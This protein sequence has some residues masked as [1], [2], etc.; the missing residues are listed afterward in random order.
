MNSG[1]SHPTI[2]NNQSGSA[3]KRLKVI[4]GDTNQ[5]TTLI[6]AIHGIGDQK[7]FETIQ[8]VAHRL[9][10]YLGFEGEAPL[11][12]FHPEFNAV[13]NASGKS[14]AYSFYAEPKVGLAEVYWADISNEAE[15]SGDTVEESKAWARTVIERLH[16]KDL[17]KNLGE[18]PSVDYQKTQ[19]VL[20][21][22]IET[23]ATLGNLFTITEKAGLFKF[24]LDN[25]LNN[26][27][28][29]VQVVADFPDYG[30][31]IFQHMQDTMAGLLTSYPDV[32]EIYLIAHSEGTVVALRS[33]LEAL[34]TN[35][36]WSNK[37]RGFMTFGSPLDKHIVLWRHLWMNLSIEKASF[38]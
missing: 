34:V 24:D 22:M 32:E 13:P 37:V 2:E 4:A 7:R 15:R 21:E 35:N 16:A 27:L 31:K 6:V 19:A 18:A 28:G 26:F 5:I 3:P 11:G 14:F 10:K 12:A 17:E 9:G 1:K 33:I 8:A 29:D 20:A 36:R 30:G 23:I 25:L 38:Y